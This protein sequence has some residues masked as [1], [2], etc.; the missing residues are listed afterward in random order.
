MIKSRSLVAYCA[1]TGGYKN[2]RYPIAGDTNIYDLVT[3][4]FNLNQSGNLYGTKDKDKDLAPTIADTIQFTT[5]TQANADPLLILNRVGSKFLPT[6]LT[7]NL[8][9]YRQDL[10]KVIIAISLPP[11]KGGFTSAK[12]IAAGSRI[13]GGTEGSRALG[14][15]ELD[16]QQSIA[17]SNAVQQIG[18]AVTAG[19]RILP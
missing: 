14:A 13:S 19:A 11:D 7:L 10:H 12:L 9:N 8:D 5:K 16:R 15:T 3:N 18:Q 1:G 4:F 17:T 2:W 6:D